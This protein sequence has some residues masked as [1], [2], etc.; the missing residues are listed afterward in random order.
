MVLVL[1][2]KYNFHI[3]DEEAKTFPGP[4]SAFLPLPLFH[5]DK[6]IQQ[7]AIRAL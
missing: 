1:E 7:G 2:R 6:V 3:V 5:K 4:H